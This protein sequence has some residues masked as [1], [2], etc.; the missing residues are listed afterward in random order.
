MYLL[1]PSMLEENLR[2]PLETEIEMR[3]I[4]GVRNLWKAQK[5][6]W[7]KNVYPP[8]IPS[9]IWNF[10]CAFS[11]WLPNFPK[12]FQRS[13]HLLES[14]YT[15]ALMQACPHFYFPP[16][17]NWNCYPSGF[18]NRSAKGDDFNAL[19]R[20]RSKLCVRE[21]TMQKWERGSL[22]SLKQK[23]K[24]VRQPT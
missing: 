18:N 6:L 15:I 21:E 5:K 12:L 1:L 7:Q 23:P 20:V 4:E 22:A 13:L 8:P 3:R 24:P 10:W 9:V 16:N 17:V 11:D 2:N 19:V 14:P